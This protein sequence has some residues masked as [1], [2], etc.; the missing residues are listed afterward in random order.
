MIWLNVYV[1]ILSRMKF[2]LSFSKVIIDC[3]VDEEDD[4]DS[5]IKQKA[6]IKGRKE[7]LLSPCFPF[8]LFSISC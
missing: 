7:A 4:D 3:D 8:V 1:K 6:E 5:I 2:V